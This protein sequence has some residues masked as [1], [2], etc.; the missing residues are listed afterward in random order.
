MKRLLVQVYCTAYFVE[1]SWTDGSFVVCCSTWR[2]R[3]D[4]SASVTGCRAPAQSRRAGCDSPTSEWLV[5]TSRT[6]STAPLESWSATRAACG[7]R[8]AAGASTTSSWSRTTR[9][10]SRRVSRTWCIS[11]RHPCSVS[12]TQSSA[13]RERTV[14]SAT[15][16]ASAWTGV[17]WCAAAA[18]TGLKRSWWWNGARVPSTGAVRSSASCAGP[19][20]QSILVCERWTVPLVKSPL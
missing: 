16:P 5:T 8:G 15:T 3:W 6:A 2:R 10:T 14:A 17:T 13:S 12:G 11:S 20:K 19:R 18:A 9:S 1:E 4:R 7:A